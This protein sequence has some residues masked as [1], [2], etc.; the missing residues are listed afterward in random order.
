[1]A[2]ALAKLHRPEVDIRKP[3][4][5]IGSDDTYSGR[6]YDEQF[7]TPFIG[8]HDLPCNPTTAFLTPALRNINTPLTAETAL[9]G[10]PKGLYRDA[11][12]LLDQVYQGAL[13]PADLLAESVRCLLLLK[14]ANQATTAVLLQR[15]AANRGA[16]NLSSEEIVTLIEQNLKSPATSRLPVLIVAA[17]Y[18]S[19]AARLGE[20]AKVLHAHNAADSQTGAVGDVEITLVN[21]ERIVTSYEMKSKR[22]SRLDID[23]ALRKIARHAPPPD[24]YI[25][26]TTDAIEPD[27]QEYARS[28]YRQIG[29]ELVVLD[30]LAFL[31]HFLHL[32]HRLRMDF[33][34]EYQRLLLSEPESAV[35]QEVKQAFLALRLAA[36]NDE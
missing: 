17:A 28:L 3:Y 27:V 1:M 6:A 2:A 10:R 5:E 7:I 11:V 9:I 13:S 4:T 30:C 33:L 18:R 32:F 24:N 16:V 20:T 35:R 26:I 36:E 8:R 15:L 19:A 29:I 12:A 21:E 14:Q 23:Q 25:F 34:D 22:V 31:R